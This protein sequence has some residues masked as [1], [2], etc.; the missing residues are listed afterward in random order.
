MNAPQELRTISF[1]RDIVP[2]KR[3]GFLLHPMRHH[4]CN[5]GDV[6]VLGR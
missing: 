1:S 5:C 6:K 2:L 4:C 3:G